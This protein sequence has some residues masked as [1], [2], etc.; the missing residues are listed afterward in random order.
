MASAGTAGAG[1]GGV[2]EGV[3]WD[4]EDGA[5][6]KENG[7]E[8]LVLGGGGDLFPDSEVGEEGLDL[9]RPEV[10]GVS[11]VVEGN[12]ALQPLDVAALGAERVE[13]AA[14]YRAGVVDQPPAWSVVHGRVPLLRGPGFGKTDAARESPVSLLSDYPPFLPQG[15]TLRGDFRDGCRRS[16]GACGRG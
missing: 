1:A 3:E 7:A 5:I 10:F 14:H 8:G 4:A 9:A 11:V 16:L 2:E 15:I 6:E 13:F 12:E